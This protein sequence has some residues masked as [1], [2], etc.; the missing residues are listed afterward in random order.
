MG[1]RR[2]L[3]IVQLISLL[4][5]SLGGLSGAW[6]AD[7]IGRRAAREAEL[8]TR[9]SRALTELNLALLGAIPFG[10]DT[11]SSPTQAALRGHLQEDREA[12]HRFRQLLDERLDALLLEDLE[13]DVHDE[14][15]SIRLLTV[16]VT[17]L[18]QRTE[19]ALPVAVPPTAPPP[20]GLLEAAARQPSLRALKGHS[21]VLSALVQRLGRQA[22]D[23]ERHHAEAMSSGVRVMV[24]TLLLAWLGG[25]LFAW[26][27]SERVL[28]P[29]SLLEQSM[30]EWGAGADQPPLELASFRD[31][32]RE[33]RSLAGSFLQMAERLSGL[34]E[35]L[36][37]LALSDSLTQV[38][39]RRRFDQALQQEWA[40]LQR[41]DRPISLLMIDVDHF[42]AY[43]DTYG[44]GQGD[45][46]LIQVAAAI[47]TE[48]RRCTDLTC[49]VGG[50]EFAMLL[51]E[52]DL[53]EALAI[54]QRTWRA[55]RGLEIPHRALGDRGHISVSIGVASAMPTLV[56][57]P[58]E[59]Q[60]RA[61]QALYRRKQH[62]GRNGV[63]VAPTPAPLVPA[64]SGP[65]A[66]SP[67]PEGG[68]PP[69]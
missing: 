67:G 20:G 68:A 14:L 30:R 7:A 2:R 61:D 52:T 36:E 46:C 38:G 59:L 8:V 1:L 63:S 69:A 39:N 53:A 11:L 34:V 43:N 35:R 9:Q 15:E 12:L 42:K 45:A 6:V 17:G 66:R 25:L 64:S 40:R 23:N 48:A 44:H 24:L 31:A 51:P 56:S 29:L 28:R 60:L 33:I 27:T 21:L 22:R 19:L 13:P 55:V 32:P 47:R 62:E 49:R 65:G 57:G 16:Q 54:A 4:I 58:Q 5:V 18:L 41:R 3:L 37:D 26:R 10:A 50:E